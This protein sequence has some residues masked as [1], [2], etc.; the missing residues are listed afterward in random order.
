MTNTDNLTNRYV[1]TDLM[2]DTDRQPDKQICRHGSDDR[3][4]QTA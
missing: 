4:R 2:T 1:D 3:H